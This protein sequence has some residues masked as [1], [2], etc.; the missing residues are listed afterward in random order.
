ME[1]MYWGDVRALIERNKKPW[2]AI[3]Y[4][5]ADSGFSDTISICDYTLPRRKGV[6]STTEGYNVDMMRDS[7]VCNAGYFNGYIP[8]R[9]VPYLWNEEEKR[10]EQKPV[11]GVIGMLQLLIKDGVIEETDEIREYLR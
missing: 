4:Y 1:G 3:R 5:R 8:L 10:W 9:D 6:I 11:R 7:F 2:A